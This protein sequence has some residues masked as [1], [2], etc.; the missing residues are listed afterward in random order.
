MPFGCIIIGYYYIMPFCYIIAIAI[1]CCIPKFYKPCIAIIWPGL[2]AGC[3]IYIP[4]GYY[5]PIG[6]CIPIGY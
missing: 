1:G 5:T 4:I 2:N 3:C 6:Y